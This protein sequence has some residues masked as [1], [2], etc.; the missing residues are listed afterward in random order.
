MWD[1]SIKQHGVVFGKRRSF[2]YAVSAF[3]LLST[4]PVWLIRRMNYTAFNVSVNNGFVSV[5][6]HKLFFFVIV[7]LLF[8]LAGLLVGL[9]VYRMPQVFL[10]LQNVRYCC[11]HQWIG[12]FQHRRIGAEVFTCFAFRL[13]QAPAFSIN[14]FL[15]FFMLHKP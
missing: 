2:G 11:V 4:M 5:L 13:H 10:F 14:I 12:I 15:G 6:K 8:G 1:S 7:A 9:E 3:D